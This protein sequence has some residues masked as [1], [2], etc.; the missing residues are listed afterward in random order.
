[1]RGADLTVQLILIA[2]QS[3]NQRS[4]V[5]NQ[6]AQTKKL[7]AESRYKRSQSKKIFI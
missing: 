5:V 1:M 7:V 2:K 3:D 4:L 6:V